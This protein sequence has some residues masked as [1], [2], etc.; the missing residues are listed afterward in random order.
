MPRI[1]VRGSELAS[2]ITCLFEPVHFPPAVG[3]SVRQL[4]I[5]LPPETSFH[6][7]PLHLLKNKGRQGESARRS[8]RSTARL[9]FDANISNQQLDVQNKISHAPMMCPKKWLG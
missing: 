5:A 7:F 4:P 9:I 8:Q 6:R 3:C 2:L 1:L